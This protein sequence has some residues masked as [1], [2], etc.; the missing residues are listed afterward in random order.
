[1]FQRLATLLSLSVLSACGASPTG[2]HVL[3]SADPAN[4]DNPF[5]D[6][7]LSGRD[8]GLGS[9]TNAYQPFIAAAAVAKGGPS[10]QTYM[11]VLNQTLASLPDSA[12]GF[13]NDGAE[14]VP[15]SESLAAASLTAAFSYVALSGT[16]ALGPEARVS[17]I[18]APPFAQVS[19]A[20][21]LAPNHS[22][23]LVLTDAAKSVAGRALTRSSDFDAWAHG[24]GATQLAA[25]AGVIH[26]DVAHIIFAMVFTT[27]NAP[28]DLVSLAG[29]IKTST[30]PTFTFAVP[31][32]NVTDC[33][34]PPMGTQCPLGIFTADAGT[35]AA[36]MPFLTE[37]IADGGAN[38]GYQEPPSEV[39]TIVTGTVVLKDMR[40]SEAGHFQP[41]M[42]AAPDTG[43]DVA[44]AFVLALPDPANPKTPLP[45]NGYPLVLVGHGLGGSN[46]VG[47]S[48]GVPNSSLCVQ[49]AQFFAAQGFGCIG[50]DAPSHGTRGGEAGF[51]RFDDL[52]ITRDY[53]RE[54]AFDQMQILRVAASGQ[55]AQF[56]AHIDKTN[57]RYFGISLGGI[58][59]STFL[60]IDPNSL[61]GVLNVPGGGLV[62]IFQSPS[63]FYD[64]GLI[65][66]GSLAIP[67]NGPNG[68][69]DPDFQA[70]IPFITTVSQ[71]LLE[72]AD[73]I[74]YAALLPSTKPLLIQEGLLDRTVPNNT[75]DDLAAAYGVQQV[76][77]TTGTP[78]GPGVDGLWKYD[79]TKYGLDPTSPDINPHLIFT[80]LPAVRAQTAVYL[81]TNGALI[82]AE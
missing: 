60:S 82:E 27:Q 49:L 10:F 11:E 80:L 55:L 32:P 75:T 79:L 72:S 37:S 16:P 25:A 61:G 69:V 13:G 64:L 62:N 45:P 58:M 51:F 76:T 5:P 34:A 54:M 21:P 78:G 30:V 63:I 67:Y 7:R 40:D 36:V 68:T 18:D 74:N 28:T 6:A 14:L 48:A 50:I 1:M 65:L 56:G 31:T 12:R 44:R 22:Y 19:P 39:G 77:A 4:P 24:D 71:V 73:P 46:S 26:L 8:G 57:L 53:F 33:T 52:T 66:Q 47:F 81:K 70:T 3:Y 42:V 38:G 17:Y 2:P 15:F 59:G 29:W 23:A 35:L 41:S 20:L 9:R 43:R